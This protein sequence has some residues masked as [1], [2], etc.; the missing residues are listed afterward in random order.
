MIYV[1]LTTSPRR[2]N[3]LQETI[4]SIMGQTILPD[5]IVINVPHIFKRTG[6]TYDEIPEY[7][8]KNDRVLINRCDD[9]GPATKILPTINLVQ[10]DDDTIISIDDDII[11]CPTFIQTLIKKSSVFP[12]SAITGTSFS[13]IHDYNPMSREM[14]YNSE[15]VEGFAG[16]LYKKWF[17]ANWEDDLD[18]TTLPK[19]CYV[20]DDL[21]LSNLLK[22]RNIHIVMTPLIKSCLKILDHGLE[23]D[24]LHKLGPNNPELRYKPCVEHLAKNNEMYLPNFYENIQQND[25]HKKKLVYY[26]VA[27][28]IF[29]IIILFIAIHLI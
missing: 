22:K 10:Q 6:E 12:N 14:Y 1:S 26:H 9:I 27:F 11:Y 17:L 8:S 25:T 20:S 18:I 3:M 23:N 16:V 4:E 28:L 15:V 29:C 19:E 7:L 5:I 13:Y 21:I 24:A 2:L